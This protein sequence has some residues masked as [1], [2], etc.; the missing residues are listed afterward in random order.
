MLKSFLSQP[1]SST[2]VPSRYLNFS[3]INFK[4][5]CEVIMVKIS[6]SSSFPDT[7]K[8]AQKEANFQLGVGCV[9][10]S[11]IRRCRN[12]KS[13]T[14]LLSYETELLGT[15]TV[16]HKYSSTHDLNKRSTLMAPKAGKNTHYR[17][18]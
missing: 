9:S 4:M 16:K 8:A 5:F 6:I 12:I 3:F 2:V 10:V 7:L 1:S 11:Y 17:A 14:H 15:C 13:K 18:D